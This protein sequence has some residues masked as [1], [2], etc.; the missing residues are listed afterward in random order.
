MEMLIT[1]LSGILAF[2][3]LHCTEGSAIPGFKYGDA[4]QK[5]ILES[6]YKG[7]AT[8]VLLGNRL[9]YASGYGRSSTGHNIHVETLLP[10]AGLSKTITA[11]AV[12]KLIEEG[13]LRSNDKIFGSNGI[14]DTLK[15]FKDDTVDAR[16]YEITVDDLLRNAGG[17][18]S[19]TSGIED[20]LFNDLL[21]ANNHKLINISKEMKLSGPANIYDI[22][23]FMMSKPLDFTPGRES[24]VSN[25]GYAVLGRVIEQVSDWDYETYVKE[26]VLT[27]CGM[28]HTKQGPHE[29]AGYNKYKG[30]T[31]KEILDVLK[32]SRE[33]IGEY[34]AYTKTVFVDSC[35]GWYSNVYDVMRLAQCIDGSSGVRL[36]NKTTT[37]LLIKKPRT[38]NQGVENWHGAGFQVHHHGAI[39]VA[40]EA[41]APDVIFFHRNLN[42][43]KDG[44]IYY[45]DE[46]E[47]MAW[48]FLL[49]GKPNI[50]SP[51]KQFSK[52]MIES[53][54]HWPITNAY[55][56][57]VADEVLTAGK[58][59]KLVKLKVEEHRINRYLKAVKQIGYN[60]QWVNAFTVDDDS[61]FM[62][63]IAKH[64]LAGSR[65][66]VA[67]AELGRDRLTHTKLK[68]EKEGYNM[69]LFQNYKSFSHTDQYLFMALFHKGAFKN[70]THIIYGLQHFDRPYKALLNLYEEKGFRPLVQS[71]EYRRDDELVSFILE[72]DANDEKDK[73]S[74]YASEDNLSESRLNKYVRKYARE[75]RKLVYLDATN[76]RGKPKFSALFMKTR[77]TKWLFS[78][79]LTYD[80]TIILLTQKQKEGFLPSIIVGNTMKGGVLHFAVY[81][82]KP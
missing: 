39:W 41:N 68:L 47:A 79:R 71:V 82:D 52:V 5:F 72:Q 46:N 19:E 9:G 25:F 3:I 17:W 75:Q 29:V 78:N 65:D 44:D 8:G 57:D 16:L 20:P 67:V 1:I 69:T 7:G 18:D 4:F 23:K 81:M 42:R 37:E 73:K 60:V 45:G 22:I 56:N 77:M 33:T 35:L 49:E 12:L 34:Y 66:S 15:P 48:V 6:G 11:L 74:I 54:T 59:T 31:A 10:L 80:E 30:K 58:T 32:E 38:S 26:A 62:A 76:H 13:K 51:L 63:V 28:W 21:V 50:D 55:L 61:T 40:T 64:D 27:P 53:E 36:L 2:G 24:K 43:H 70:D 14:L